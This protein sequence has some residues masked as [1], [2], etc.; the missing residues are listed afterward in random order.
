[1]QQERVGAVDREQQQAACEAGV[2]PRAQRLAAEEAARL[3]PGD[4]E[5]EAGLERRVVGADVV[6]PVA[7]TLLDAAGVEAVMAGMRQAV[8]R[9]GPD[10]RGMDGRG[11]ALPVL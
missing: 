1:M 8:R 7:E 4:G 3:V 6:A 9:A 2:A 10:Q 5:A 11:V